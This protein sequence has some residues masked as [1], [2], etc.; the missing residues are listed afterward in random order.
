MT[1]NN[2]AAIERLSNLEQERRVI[3]SRPVGYEACVTDEQA[4]ELTKNQLNSLLS[5]AH[6]PS[7]ALTS[8]NGQSSWVNQ[9]RQ[10]DD[11]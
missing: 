8:A 11:R 5:A 3:T 1:S 10:R 4:R 2:A 9:H 6:F 7:A